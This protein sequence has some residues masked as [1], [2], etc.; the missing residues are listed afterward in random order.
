MS[1]LKELFFSFVIPFLISSISSLA[2]GNLRGYIKS[3]AKTTT[4]NKNKKYD[5]LFVWYVFNAEY[6]T[7]SYIIFTFFYMLWFLSNMIAKIPCTSLVH[8]IN[9]IATLFLVIHT[10]MHNIGTLYCKKHNINLTDQ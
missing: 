4:T 7:S 3:F 1:I 9:P 2:T 10:I 6:F 8:I 5:N